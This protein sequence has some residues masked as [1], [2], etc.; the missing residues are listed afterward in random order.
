PRR[1]VGAREL[2]EARAGNVGR[3]VPRL[4]HAGH[5]VA[6]PVQNERREA[7]GGRK[8]PAFSSLSPPP[9]PPPPPGPGPQPLV[10]GRPLPVARV[11]AGCACIALSGVA[12]SRLDGI[13]DGLPFLLGMSKGAI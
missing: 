7:D 8:G 3:Q 12:P 4:F 11:R 6:R 5:A 1:V 13:D 2:D 9:A 10:R